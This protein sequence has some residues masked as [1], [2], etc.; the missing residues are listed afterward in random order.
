MFKRVMTNASLTEMQFS[1]D[2]AEE[3]IG[4]LQGAE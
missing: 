1:Y 2:T 4:Q 3:L